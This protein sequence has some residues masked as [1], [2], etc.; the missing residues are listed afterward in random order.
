MRIPANLV[1]DVYRP[2]SL[3]SFSHK[4]IAKKICLTNAD[5][6]AL[7]EAAARKVQNGGSDSSSLQPQMA[8]RTTD[9]N[10]VRSVDC[11]LLR[12]LFLTASKQHFIL[13]QLVW[14]CVLDQNCGLRAGWNQLSRV[15]PS[16]QKTVKVYFCH[17]YDFKHTKILR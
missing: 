14:G 15:M 2:Q 13:P 4:F 6:A 17:N 7:D 10:A 12:T 16:S 9:S 5:D 11:R 1:C 3:T 8:P